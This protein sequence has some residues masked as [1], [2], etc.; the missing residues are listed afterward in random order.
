[1]NAKSIS[2]AVITGVLGLAVGW[3]VAHRGEAGHDHSHESSGATEPGKKATYQCPMHPWIKS[4][5]PGSKCTICGMDLV[6]AGNT[7]S[8]ETPPGVVSLSPSTITVLGVK[9][10]IAAKRALQRTVRVA[11]MVDD[12]DTKHRFLTAYV[13]GRVEQLHVNFV[14]AEVMEGQP[15]LTIYSPDLLSA[16]REFL[17]IVKG[18]ESTAPAVRPARERLRG[19]G[20]T[21]EQIEKLTA[22]GEPEQSTTLY[23]PATG[24][25]ITRGAY[26]GQSVAAGD[27]LFE[28]ADFSTMWF[29]F[30]AYEQDLAWIKV[31]Q[32]VEVTT[33]AV[34]GKVF[35]AKVSFIDPNFNEMTR[36]TRVRVELPNPLVGEGAEARREIPHRVFGEGIVHVEAPAVLT[37]PRTAVLNAGNGSVV[38]VDRGS[39]SYEQRRIKPG[40]LGDDYMEVFEGV[41]EGDAVVTQGNLLIDAQAQLSHEATAHAS[42]GEMTMPAAKDAGAV[43][44]P[45][46]ATE[47]P[48]A[49]PMERLTTLVAAASE[50]ADALASDDFVRYQSV[51]PKLHDASRDLNL[52]ILE[53]GADLKAARRSFEV[54]STTVADLARP[55]REHLGIKVYECPMAPVLK[56]GRWVQKEGPL[57]NPFFGSLMLTCGS[58]L[59]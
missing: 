56:K 6:V 32:R 24:T 10:E 22:S 18:G 17:Q 5:K 11:G 35:V 16:Q 21:N 42:H 14:G 57:K 48:A 59:N 7:G 30:E 52:P 40:R 49:V 34:P 46:S 4:D 23:S 51:F 54:W 27:K 28:I 47:A 36:V 20:L 9:T 33:R 2:I 41:S 3:F 55:H 50:G 31:G 19:L 15:L 38:Y 13:P 43:P 26:P 37:V 45:L 44:A 25:I 1:M 12:D 39:N 29:Q 8:G 53:K 58:E